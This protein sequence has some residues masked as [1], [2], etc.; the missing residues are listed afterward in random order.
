MLRR[1]NLDSKSCKVLDM[2]E[3]KLFRATGKYEMLK[4]SISLHFVKIR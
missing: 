4:L 2:N 3:M 1:K